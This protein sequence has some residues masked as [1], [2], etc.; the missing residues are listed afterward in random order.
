MDG[1]RETYGTQENATTAEEHRLLS[2]P[3]LIATFRAKS[4]TSKSSRLIPWRIP[5]RWTRRL[6]LASSQTGGDSSSKSKTRKSESSLAEDDHRTVLKANGKPRRTAI[7]SVHRSSRL[8]I[9]TS[10]N[11]R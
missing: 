1:M 10:K 5:L 2:P 6:A 3:I 8:T 9:S 4:Q 7:K 11:F